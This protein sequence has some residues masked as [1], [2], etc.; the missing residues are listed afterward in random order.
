V[1]RASYWSLLN[2]PTAGLTYGAH[3][4][5][6]WEVEPKEPLLHSGTGIAKPWFE[7]MN[8]PGSLQMKYLHEFFASLQW[9]ELRPDASLLSQSANDPAKFIAAAKTRRGDLAVV[10]LPVGGEIAIP[11]VRQAQWFDPRT[12]RWRKAIPRA[13]TFQASSTE[14]WLLKV[15]LK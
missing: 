12:G 11:S 15:R 7:A 9:W 13:G 10:Y 5:W 8:L 4:V 2:A 1:R 14:D 3:G 6:S